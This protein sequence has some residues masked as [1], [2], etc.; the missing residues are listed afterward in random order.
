MK[1][2]KLFEQYSDIDSYNEEDWGID[3]ELTSCLSC[4]II[5]DKDCNDRC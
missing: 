5:I 2:L 4:G 3:I 1:Y